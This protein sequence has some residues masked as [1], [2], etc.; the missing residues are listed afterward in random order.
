RFS[1]EID[2]ESAV[3]AYN[4]FIARFQG[5]REEREALEKKLVVVD[6]KSLSALSKRL[7]KLIADI[8]KFL[9]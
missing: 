9:K 2:K 5:I 4:G 3:Y 7:D 1:R 8:L 6:N